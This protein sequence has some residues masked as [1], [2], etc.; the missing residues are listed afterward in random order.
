PALEDR[1][2]VVAH[3]RIRAG[4]RERGGTR[5]RLK[6]G[7]ERQPPRSTVERGDERVSNAGAPPRAG[8]VTGKSSGTPT[9]RWRVQATAIARRAWGRPGSRRLRCM[10]SDNRHGVMGDA[11]VRF[12]QVRRRRRV[13]LYPGR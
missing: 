3:E 13:D 5:T 6:A 1:R 11:A 7:A 9:P 8:Q 12:T 4:R 2:V 10:G